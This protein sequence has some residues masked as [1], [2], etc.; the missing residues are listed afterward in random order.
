RATPREERPRHQ[1][2]LAPIAST[3]CGPAGHGGVKDRGE[4]SSVVPG[5]LSLEARRSALELYRSSGPL[6]EKRPP[7]CP[8][9]TWNRC[10]PRPPRATSSTSSPAP[11]ST[12][13]AS[14]ASTC[15][16]GSP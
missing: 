5:L 16:A 4:R 7:P 8:C 13:A 14:A 1:G 11:A 10:R 9:S 2:R 6:K 15:A 12:A 3:C